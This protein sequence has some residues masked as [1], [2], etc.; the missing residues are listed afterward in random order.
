MPTII[1]H[2]KHLRTQ[3]YEDPMPARG[4]RQYHLSEQER[5][6]V[7]LRLETCHPPLFN[8]PRHAH[9]PPLFMSCLQVA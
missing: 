8:I 9:D 4:L 6:P 5:S 7:F 2:L 1:N 3:Y